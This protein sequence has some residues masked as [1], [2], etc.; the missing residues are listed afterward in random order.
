MPGQMGDADGFS[1]EDILIFDVLLRYGAHVLDEKG[2]VLAGGFAN[3]DGVAFAVAL[4]FILND[5]TIFLYL[6]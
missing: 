1:V 6:C 4:N 2:T 5:C 3:N